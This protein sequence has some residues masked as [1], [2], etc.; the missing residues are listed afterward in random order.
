MVPV[1]RVRS[2]MCIAMSLGWGRAKSC[3]APQLA[4][5]A[6]GPECLAILAQ[7]LQALQAELRKRL[8]MS[9]SHQ[10]WRVAGAQALSR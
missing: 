1:E 5:F 6:T 4:Q 3:T 8:S 2:D 10:G 7:G 9:S